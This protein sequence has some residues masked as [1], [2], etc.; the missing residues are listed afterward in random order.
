[1]EGRNKDFNYLFFICLDGKIG[2][3]NSS[4]KGILFY[5]TCWLNQCRKTGDSDDS[6]NDDNDGHDDT[7]DLSLFNIDYSTQWEFL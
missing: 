4:N 5:V 7:E 1:M 3:T 6:D 2:Y